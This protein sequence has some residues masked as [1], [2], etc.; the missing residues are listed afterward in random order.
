MVRR[1]WPGGLGARGGRPEGS[2]KSSISS[3]GAVGEHPG[4]EEHVLE[5]ADVAGPGERAEALE[6]GAGDAAPIAVVAGGEDAEEVVDEHGQV[7]EALAERG[8]ADLDDVEAVVE[9]LAEEAGLDHGRE[10]AVGGGDDPGVD[11]LLARAADGAH[12]LLLEH[13]E[14]A[15]LHLLRHLADLVEEDGALGRLPEQALPVAVGP[16]ERAPH[17]AEELALQEVLGD[18]AAV[19]AEEGLL[20]PRAGVVDGAGHHLLAGAALAG[21]EDG[22]VGVL[23][24]I[25]ERVHPAHGLAGADQA[26]VAEVAADH[27]ARR[28]QIAPRRL[29]LGGAVAEQLLE[30]GA[31]GLELLVGE[32]ELLGAPR[33]LADEA[34]GLDGD[35][36]LVGERAQGAQ[37]VAEALGGAQPG[38]Q[39]E[40]ADHPAGS[41]P[42]RHAGHRLEHELVDREVAGHARV[43]A[44]AGG[45]HRL[46]GRHHLVGDRLREARVR[47]VALLVARGV[48]GEL[49]GRRRNPTPRRPTPLLRAPLLRA[50]P[51]LLSPALLSP[52]LL[53][54]SDLLGGGAAPWGAVGVSRS[55]VT[56][57]ARA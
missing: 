33:V 13:A 9:I 56:G 15:G 19:D 47:V 37:L 36:H 35:G 57:S 40:G 49:G 53:S 42:D 30:L 11:R 28:A 7:V 22:H 39:V 16:R 6:G 18:G 29:E 52:A 2:S 10:I 46:A 1:G 55:T 43:V 17:V 31:R 26:L 8:D 38:L 20:P 3:S 41:R 54:P 51:A 48:D 44:G 34:R 23:D 21:D 14:Q 50:S 32:R 25:D 45:H 27:R 5:L 4:V 24:P 12:H